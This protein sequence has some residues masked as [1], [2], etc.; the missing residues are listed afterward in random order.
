MSSQLKHSPLG[1]FQYFYKA[2]GNKLLFNLV[3][4]V[5]LGLMDGIGLAL[6]MPLLQFVNSSDA[7]V[8]GDA[9][10][11]MAFIIESFSLVGVPL[12][13]F[14]VL[15]MMVI[16]FVMKGLLN[17]WLTMEQVDLRQKYMITLRLNQVEHL[18]KLSYQGF[19]KLD[20]GRIQNAVT[21]EI[22]KNIQA[23]KHFLNSSK[24][25]IVLTSYIV[26]AFVANWKFALFILVGG[27]L[28]NFLY[29][30]ITNS[31]KASSL[32]I[33]KRGNLF[34]GYIIQAVHNFKYLK[35]TNQF[36]NFAIKLKGV[37]KEVERLNRKIGR[38]Q[39]ITLSSREP[40]IIF[41][42][43]IVILLQVNLMGSSLGSI[44]LSLLLFYRA[45]NGLVVVQMSWQS[46]MQNIGGL[47]SISD[48]N[49]SMQSA[50][51]HQP[52]LS[53]EGFNQQIALKKISF[54]YGSNHVLKEIDMLIPKNQTIALVG[55]SG[56]GKST[57]ANII[58]TLL[59][60]VD[61]Q[62]LVDGK[63]VYQYNLDS[64][65]SRI[66]YITQEPVI[67][68]DNIYNNITFWA[69]PTAE[70]LSRFWEVIKKVSLLDFVENSAFKE[71]TVL[72]DNGMMVSGGQKQRISIARELFKQV[73]I[74]ILDEATSAL[75]SQTER[76]IQNSIDELQGE[77]TMIV[78]AHRLS[79]IQNADVIYLIDHGKIS[80]SGNY[81]QLLAN[82]ER[83]QKMVFLQN[84]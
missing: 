84:V 23:L 82:S 46:F 69:K 7:P 21:T 78:I 36:S 57:L 65:R 3:L 19:L 66:G 40:V 70:N 81:H 10:G 16:V 59:K 31:V 26:L 18:R 53:Y 76:F 4:A 61:G 54:S 62:L 42:V 30:K 1:Y 25:V 34:S 12:N 15:S 17:Y 80:A 24:A 14:S 44:L 74:L 27:Y 5:L 37:I 63:D 83:F 28:S 68:S 55:E 29:K 33:S 32:D 58:T 52:K 75:D 20:A 43:A 41:I 6:F 38:G 47:Q 49:V 11:G 48:L 51:E 22:G 60:S 35:A 50:V 45:L 71:K 13:L 2:L 77:Y 39:A 67:F 73:D 79:T 64:F 8:D 56:S 72:G 9:M